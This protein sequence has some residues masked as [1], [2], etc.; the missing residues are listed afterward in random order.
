M[1]YLKKISISFSYIPI[2]FMLSSCFQE[3]HSLQA[4]LENC[5]V[6]YKLSDV[7]H[8]QR[9]FIDFVDSKTEYIAYKEFSKDGMRLVSVTKIADQYI[10]SVSLA[11]I[12]NGTLSKNIDKETGV[13]LF[14]QTQAAT[15]LK[16][17]N[18]GDDFHANCVIVGMKT[19]GANTY[20]SLYNPPI[21]I[22]QYGQSKNRG[23][24]IY[25][26]LTN[27]LDEQL[28][29]YIDKIISINKST[30]DVIN[31]EEKI[32]LADNYVDATPKESKAFF[33]KL[34]KNPFF[35]I[36]EKDE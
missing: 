36:I 15:E 26:V 5:P 19:T 6:D 16:N 11:A 1:K 35:E 10:L 28:P 22:D 21:L 30:S 7:L 12:P 3:K 31:V 13:S 34:I 24:R 9:Y 8:I 25:S 23:L 18:G 33:Q 32:F 4:M 2:V 14:A 27:L 20:A 29:N 17:Y